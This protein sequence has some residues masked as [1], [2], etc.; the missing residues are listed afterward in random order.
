MEAEA[1]RSGPE[2]FAE[3][4]AGQKHP[5]LTTDSACPHCLTDLPE[6]W[7]DAAGRCPQCRLV[8]GEGRALGD[9]GDRSPTSTG[10]A[11]LVANAARRADA[12]AGDVD[13]VA[14]AL[15]KVAAQQDIRVER[16]GML[17]YQRAAKD[18]PSL[19]PLAVVLATFSHWK[20]AR[21]HAALQTA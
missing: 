6:G 21:A 10:A 15:A 11:N 3:G 7:T 18:D 12:D 13:E 2:R 16:L 20:T 14:A 1:P 8:I 4:S 19:P 5:T 17:D 9:L